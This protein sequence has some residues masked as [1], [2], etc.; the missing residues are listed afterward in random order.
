MVNGHATKNPSNLVG[1]C[2]VGNDRCDSR[3]DK[4]VL[5]FAAG[6]G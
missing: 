1:D 5:A 2:H 6:I 4:S 3:S